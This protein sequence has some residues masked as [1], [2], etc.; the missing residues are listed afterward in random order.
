[1]DSSCMKCRSTRLIP[2]QGLVDQGQHSDGHLKAIV[3]YTRPGA[4]FRKGPIFA[5]LKAT[6][7][8]ECGHTELTA[9]D[10]AALYR[11]WIEHRSKAD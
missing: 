3:T 7:C 10:P 2:L 8:G 6:I 9:V 11:S 1:M 4:W 5:Q